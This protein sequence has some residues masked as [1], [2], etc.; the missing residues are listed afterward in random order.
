MLLLQFSAQTVENLVTRQLKSQECA[1][2]LAAWIPSQVEASLMRILSFSIPCSLY[3]LIS[4]TALVTL[5]A[6]SKDSLKLKMFNKMFFNFN[7]D[8]FTPSIDL[9]GD[10]S[11]DDF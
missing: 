4:L 5:P 8:I 6:L 9:G 2:Y 3:I 7:F 11:G 1:A 10:T